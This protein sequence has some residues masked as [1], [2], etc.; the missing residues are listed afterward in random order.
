M[1]ITY[2]FLEWENVE[3]E[4]DESWGDVILEF[5][6][7]ECNNNHTETRRHTSLDT[8]LEHSDWLAD[9]DDYISSL[10]AEPTKT[11]I[12]RDAIQTLKPKQKELLKA[13]YFDGLTQEQYAA[14]IGVTQGAVAQQHKTIL[15][16]LKK[17][18]EKT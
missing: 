13:L 9:D 2:E 8:S 11:D 12:L 3:I 7:K 17:F 15:K 5:N 10:F 18:F 1:K 6:K 16:K 4:V 14:K